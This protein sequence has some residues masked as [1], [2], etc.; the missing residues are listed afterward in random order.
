MNILAELLI[1][2]ANWRN[3]VKK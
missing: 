1:L 3:S 2:D